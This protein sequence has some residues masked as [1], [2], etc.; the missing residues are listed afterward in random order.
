MFPP[1][2]SI[3]KRVEED[4]AITITNAA[5]ERTTIPMPEGSN[6]SMHVP[7]LHY[8]RT[9]TLFPLAAADALTCT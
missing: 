1:V 9:F 5:G 6:I 4:T 7:G 2:V 3:P 8:N